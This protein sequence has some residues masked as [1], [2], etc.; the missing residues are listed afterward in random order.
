MKEK[1]N[2]KQI[3]EIFEKFCSEFSQFINKKSNSSNKEKN[4]IRG[5]IWY[6]DKLFIFL[7]SKYFFSFLSEEEKNSPCFPNFLKNYKK[8][9]IR[10]LCPNGKSQQTSFVMEETLKFSEEFITV[11]KFWVLIKN[12]VFTESFIDSIN[13]VNQPNKKFIISD[14]LRFLY[15]QQSSFKKSFFPKAISSLLTDFDNK[16]LEIF[17]LY[18]FRKELIEKFFKTKPD[19]S[20]DITFLCFLIDIDSKLV[21]ALADI[22]SFYENFGILVFLLEIYP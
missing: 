18:V 8:R 21:F 6:Y 3:T 15:S 20:S 7:F 9:E 12:S 16:I 13:K 10:D 11:R 5:L 22:I 4:L 19:I 14:K 1:N 2:I 17:K